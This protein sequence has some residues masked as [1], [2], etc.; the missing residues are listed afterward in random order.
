MKEERKQGHQKTKSPINMSE[1]KNSKHP[2]EDKN[3]KKLKGFSN[4]FI[5]NQKKEKKSKIEII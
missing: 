4:F 1:N 3:K 5:E 2:F